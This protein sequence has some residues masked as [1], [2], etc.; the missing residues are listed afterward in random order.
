MD[1]LVDGG[2]RDRFLRRRTWRAD[3]RRLLHPDLCVQASRTS[4]GISVRTTVSGI[5]RNEFDS[6]AIGDGTAGSGTSADL[7]GA[8]R[9]RRHRPGDPAA[10]LRPRRTDPAKS[11][12]RDR[13]VPRRDR[14]TRCLAISSPT[15]TTSSSSA[16]LPA[17]S[18]RPKPGLDG[19]G[20]LVHMCSQ[21]HNSR[22]D[23][24][25]SRARFNVMTLDAM[26]RQERDPAI[27][28]LQLA[29]D[30]PL[31]MPPPR[32][33]HALGRQPRRDRRG[34]RS[35]RA[36][37]GLFVPGARNREITSGESP[38][39]DPARRRLW[40]R[41]HALSGRAV[42]N[43]PRATLHPTRGPTRPSTRR[44]GPRSASVEIS[45]ASAT[46]PRPPARRQ[47]SARRRVRPGGRH[48][49]SVHDLQPCSGHAR[50]LG[51]RDSITGTTSPITF[52]PRAPRRRVVLD[53]GLGAEAGV[54]PG[55]TITVTAAGGPDV[56]AFT[57]SVTAPATLAGYTPPTTVARRLH[58]D[59]DGEQAARRSG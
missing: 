39:P 10:V 14:R 13:R 41:S 15:R 32:F 12:R 34:S 19:R 11:T 22:L 33:L 6:V 18:I 54:R 2:R 35:N 57:A 46:A 58:R 42:G 20:I 40:Q 45:R 29:D 49:R 37:P 16:A 38:R 5:N 4:N 8:V 50:L 53:R 28:R 21:C 23:Q 52:D 31:K 1:A 3:L 47:R 43:E 59:V 25:L 17:M 36:L 55:A 7:A 30:D 27:A 9:Q 51:G 44:P 48:R 26:S 24:T 56:G